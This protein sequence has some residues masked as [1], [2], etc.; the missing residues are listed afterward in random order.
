MM[1]LREVFVVR[2]AGDQQ[3]PTHARRDYRGPTIRWRCRALRE[4]ATDNVL[5]KVGNP[6]AFERANYMKVLQ[7]YQ[8]KVV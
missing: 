7:S 3:R 8:V 5:G 6:A 4:P 1:S 2:G